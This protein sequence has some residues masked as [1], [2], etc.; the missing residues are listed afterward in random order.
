MGQLGV[1]GERSRRSL[2]IRRHQ[3][4]GA[5]MSALTTP[6]PKPAH[7]SATTMIAC[8]ALAL[9]GCAVGILLGRWTSSSAPA[10]EHGVEAAASQ[11]DMRPILEEI[12]RAIEA[13]PQAMRV[14]H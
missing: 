2:R 8:V 6:N 1:V 10:S 14:R 13:L 5:N 3:P 11:A 9:S 12:R 4:R 7:F